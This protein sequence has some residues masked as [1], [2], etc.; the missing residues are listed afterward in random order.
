[1][2]IQP[3]R[4]VSAWAL[5][6]GSG[7]RFARDAFGPVLLFYIGW[8]LVGFRTAIVAATTLAIAAYLWERRQAR[9]G[10]TAGIGL[11]IPL[12]QAT[13]GLAS[14]ST[15]G[16]FAPPL[17]MNGAYGLA[18]RVGHHRPAASQ[19]F[20][21]RDVFVP[22]ASEGVADISSSVFPDL[23]RVGGVPLAAD[24]IAIRRTVVEQC[25][26]LR[27][28]QRGDGHSLHGRAHELVDLVRRAKLSAKRR[29]G[30]V[31]HRPLT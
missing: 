21:A 26:V 5:M 16:H 3:R 7:P 23:T 31:P 18:F 1:M 17:V 20:C 12:V 13:A 24:G 30:S 19:H 14:G 27:G 10:I 9:S 11:A 2:S 4:G 22:S 29:M 6:R 25:R 15:T 8:K 28:D